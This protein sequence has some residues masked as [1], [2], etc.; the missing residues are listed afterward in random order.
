M[1]KI[2]QKGSSLLIIIF[3]ITLLI[4]VASSVSYYVLMSQ[5]N[6][7]QV[8]NNTL[9]QPFADVTPEPEATAS[10]GGST[11][12]SDKNDTNTL[13]E[14][15]KNTSTENI[16]SDFQELDKSASSL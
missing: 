14:E 7:P 15:F 2:K 9:Y 11:E 13:E 1:T 4:A 10:Q 8:S 6:A 16:D 5:G 12:I 3:I